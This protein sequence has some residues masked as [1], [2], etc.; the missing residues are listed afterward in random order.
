[1]AFKGIF[2]MSDII[3]FPPTETLLRVA[4]VG[5]TKSSRYFYAQLIL[6]LL[7]GAFIAFA[8]NASTIASFN[9]LARPETF[10]LGKFVSG[11][12]FPTGLIFVVLAG[13][14]LFT[15][16]CLLVVSVLEKRIRF[17]QML[18]NWGLVYLGNIIGSLLVVMLV[19]YSGQLSSA[20]NALGGTSIKLAYGKLS[21]H[22]IQ[23]FCLGVLCNWL[24]CLAVW[25]SLSVKDILGKV[26]SCFFPV[27][28][29][30]TAGFEHSIANLYY[31]PIGILATHVPEYVQASALTNEALQHLTVHNFLFKNL[32][33]VTIGN[34]V[35]GVGFGIIMWIVFKPQKKS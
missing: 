21:F 2:R 28:V 27:L 13:A 9:L 32:I 7:A 31:V 11:L 10:G 4:D 25:F 24:V 34:I 8:S 5:Y 30:V 18:K 19:F 14:E 17:S 23:S 16:N 3:L 35:G 22:F 6:A 1:M 26:L 33:P 20:G 12:V 15:G 29:F